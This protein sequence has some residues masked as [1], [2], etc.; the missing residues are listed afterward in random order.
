MEH[1][2]RQLASLTGLVQTALTV[3]GASGASV[4][5]SATGRAQSTPG[6]DGRAEIGTKSEPNILITNHGL[7]TAS[8]HGK[9]KSFFSNNFLVL[10]SVD[11][12]ASI[13]HPTSS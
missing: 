2:E 8:S 4:S 11:A 5:S 3:S 10:P 12:F 7:S 9:D 1:V 6:G 13:V